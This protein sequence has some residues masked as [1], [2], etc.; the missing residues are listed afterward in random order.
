MRQSW[1]KFDKALESGYRRNW[2]IPSAR[3][4]PELSQPSEVLL[5]LVRQRIDH[6]G[7][8][9][10]YGVRWRTGAGVPSDGNRP[11]EPRGGHQEAEFHLAMQY[12]R[13]CLHR[14]TAPGR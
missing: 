2:A 3:Q 4:I 8:A 6:Y 14:R 12:L 13:T 1:R 7:N 5:L 9:T 11:R 10:V